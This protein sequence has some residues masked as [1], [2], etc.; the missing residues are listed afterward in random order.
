MTC[1]Q[2]RRIRERGDR[3]RSEAYVGWPGAPAALHELTYLQDLH[4]EILPASATGHHPA[5]GG[6]A[7][8]QQEGQADWKTE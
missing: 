5:E 4:A 8:R 6:H 1:L 7:P 3:G 2:V